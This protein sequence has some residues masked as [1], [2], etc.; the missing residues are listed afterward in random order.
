MGTN[1]ILTY[2]KKLLLDNKYS[3]ALSLLELNKLKLCDSAELFFLI[4]NI[5]FHFNDLDKALINFKTSLNLLPSNPFTLNN[6]GMCY[7][8]KGYQS[9]ACNFFQR[10][11]NLNNKYPLF[12]YNLINNFPK[13]YKDEKEIEKYYSLFKSEIN[14]LL[15]NLQKFLPHKLLLEEIIFAF[16]NFSLP[17]SGRNVL[18]NQKL[19][20]LF[21]ETIVRSYFDNVK[22]YKNLKRI[23]KKIKIGFFSNFFWNHTVNKEFSNF[24]VKTNK[25]KFD[26]FTFSFGKKNDFFTSLIKN[27]SKFYQSTNLLEMMAKIYEEKLDYLIFYDIGMT[28]E[29]QIISSFRLAKTQCMLWGHPVS[30]SFK[31]IDYFI[32]SELMEPVESDKHYSEKLLKLP[33][34]GICYSSDLKDYKDINFNEKSFLVNQSLFK[35]LPRQDKYFSQILKNLPDFKINFIKSTNII[36]TKKFKKRIKKAFFNDDVNINR[37]FFLNR[38]SEQG[39]LNYIKDSKIVLDTFDWSGG[40]TSLFSLSMNKPIVTMPSN[41]MRG[42]HTYAMLKLL[43]LDCLIANNEQQYIDIAIKLAINKNF[44]KECC[45]KIKNNKFKLFDDIEVIKE[46]EKFLI[47]NRH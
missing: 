40:L 28:Q 45:E 37:L 7:Q 1:D 18:K 21:Y 3:E 41:F 11:K 15:N 44:Y 27:N 30:S 34:L 26:V 46:F 36:E 8:R 5:H 14:D 39:F 17:Y 42:R 33:N 9:L 12:S 25:E 24:I 16:T 22:E 31:N 29:S 43:G 20:A 6:I 10:A 4:G 23:N 19:Y 35:I 38:T 13:I 32:S 2:S 47:K